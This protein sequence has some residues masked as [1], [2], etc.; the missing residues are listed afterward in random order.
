MKKL[1]ILLL[2]L[3]L[4]LGVFA[5]CNKRYLYIEDETSSSPSEDAS[6]E[7]TTDITETTSETN[8]I[9][10]ITTK[11]ITEDPLPSTS[12]EIN[13]IDEL[14]EIRKMLESDNATKLEQY[15][16]SGIKS[17]ADLNAFVKLIDS[18]PHISILDGSITR[19]RFS[20]SISEDTGKETNVV[21]I[22]TEA[23]NGDWTR[24][25]YVLSVTNIAKKIADEKLSIGENSYIDAPIKTSN[26]RLILH[27]ETR[28]P[29]PSG[30]GTMIQWVG[31]AEGIFTRIYYYTDNGSDVKTDKLFDDLQVCSL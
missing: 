31:D 7:S 14:N 19:I 6:E 29:H 17:K 15:L 3:T 13:G 2:A 9:E 27:I 8:D 23:D 1:I 28:K 10:R 11:V 16:H 24:V 30:V 18:L 22:T 25:E 26:D 4:I 5:S 21:Y 12:I 20:R